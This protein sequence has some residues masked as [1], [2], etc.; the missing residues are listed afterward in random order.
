MP[1]ADVENGDGNL[2]DPRAVRQELAR[3]KYSQ[4]LYRYAAGAEQA[5]EDPHFM[6]FRELQRVNIIHVQ[7]ELARYKAIVRSAESASAE[8]LSHL[9]KLVHDYGKPPKYSVFPFSRITNTNDVFS[10]C[11]P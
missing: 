7:N 11:D 9:R 8:D 5:N 1:S 2:N 6:I 4:R 3:M 10:Q